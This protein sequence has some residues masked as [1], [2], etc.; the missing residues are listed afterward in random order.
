MASQATQSRCTG[1][2]VS[3]ALSTLAIC[4]GRLKLRAVRRFAFLSLSCARDKQSQGA[5]KVR[6]TQSSLKAAQ[7][8]CCVITSREA[9]IFAHLETLA[10]GFAHIPCVARGP[11]HPAGWSLF[12]PSSRSGAPFCRKH[13]QPLPAIGECSILSTWYHV[14]CFSLLD[15]RFQLT[16]PNVRI[17][18]R[19]WLKSNHYRYLADTRARRLRDYPSRPV[20]WS[21]F[22]NG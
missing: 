13:S 10:S 11:S 16:A 15:T 8:L 20:A 4:R 12:G 6:L 17:K 3:Q 19:L 18:V 1:L 5:G 21:C 2:G 9:H 14:P 7:Y 22:W